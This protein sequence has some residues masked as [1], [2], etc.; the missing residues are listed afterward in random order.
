MKA[1]NLPDTATPHPAEV[2]A[3]PYCLVLGFVLFTPNDYRELG[4]AGCA[5]GMVVGTEGKAPV[6][7]HR[8]VGDLEGIRQLID[9]RLDQVF[10]YTKESAEICEAATEDVQ[11]TT[12]QERHAE[13]HSALDEI[14]AEYV[15][16]NKCSLSETNVLQL[17]NWSATQVKDPTEDDD[18]EP[19]AV[20]TD[21][22]AD[23]AD[24]AADRPQR[25]DG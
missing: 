5:P 12:H 9:E 2:G 25:D 18:N 3:H 19:Q 15:T 4:F 11:L 22:Q 20:E 13:L 24:G 23:N 8:I 7:M 10:E 17:I 6:R 16:H 1:Y 14:V 21:G